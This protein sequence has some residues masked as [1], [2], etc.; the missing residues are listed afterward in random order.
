MIVKFE[1]FNFNIT[2]CYYDLFIHLSVNDKKCFCFYNDLFCLNDHLLN[3]FVFTS[4]NS[5]NKK[6]IIYN[7]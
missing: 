2:K 7:V 3:K 4:A 6:V 5:I 1:L